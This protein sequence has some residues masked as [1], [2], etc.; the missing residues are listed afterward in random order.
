MKRFGDA[1]TTIVIEEKLHGDEISVCCSA[2][3]YFT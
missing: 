2:L 1:G 3:K